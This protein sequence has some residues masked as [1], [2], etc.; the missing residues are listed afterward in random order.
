MRL[1]TLFLLLLLLA[2]QYPLWLGKGGWLRVWDMQKQVT[3]QNQ[4]NAELKLRNTKLEGEVKDLKEGTGAI[5]ERAR[6]ELGMVK[7]DEG[8]VQF[9]GPAPKISE[10]PPPPP[11]PAGQQP[12]H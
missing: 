8:F 4:R 12:H 10:T 9:V 6:Y 2:I 11:P 3:A 7:D 5:E 1:I